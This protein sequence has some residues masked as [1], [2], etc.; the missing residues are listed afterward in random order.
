LLAEPGG[1]VSGVVPD[2]SSS[3][4]VFPSTC[5]SELWGGIA[6]VVVWGVVVEGLSELVSPPVWVSLRVPVVVRPLGWRV[7]PGPLLSEGRQCV[8]ELHG[9]EVP[10]HQ[11]GGLP[12]RL[13][14]RPLVL[15]QLVWLLRGGLLDP[16]GVQ[17][18][19]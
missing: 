16:R 19:C 9:G 6:P 14:V 11:G 10:E 7:V 13:L 3:A 17:N 1:L 18:R 4:S 15:H 12:E 8:S 5:C 2:G